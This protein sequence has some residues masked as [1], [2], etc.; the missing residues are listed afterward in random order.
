MED[1]VT[2]IALK[3]EHVILGGDFNIHVEDSNDTLAEDFMD[4]MNSMG[5]EQVI[6]FPTHIKGGTLDLIFVR[7]RL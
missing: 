1:Y 6:D 7:N 3:K 4:L 2:S 5:F